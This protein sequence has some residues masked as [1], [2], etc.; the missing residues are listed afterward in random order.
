LDAVGFAS[1][2]PDPDSDVSDLQIR[3]PRD[4]LE[5]GQLISAQ[6]LIVNEVK[7][8]VRFSIKALDRN[9]KLEGT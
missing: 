8:K 5:I 6:V 7:R 9:L 2:G 3:D 4:V 1:D